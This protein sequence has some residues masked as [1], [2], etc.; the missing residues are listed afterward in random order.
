MIGA[1]AASFRAYSV[2]MRKTIWGILLLWLTAA[3]TTTAQPAADHARQ[4]AELNVSAL[5]P[6]QHAVLAVGIDISEGFHAQSR[7]PSNEYLIAFD[8]TMQPSDAIESYQPIYP[9]GEDHT[10]EV[11]GTL[12]VYTGK[13]IVYVPMV[14][15]SSAPIGALTL[16]GTMTY[17]ICDERACFQPENPSFEVTTRVVPVSEI[18]TPVNAALFEK[19]D[20]KV[21]ANLLP[22]TEVAGP[23][24]GIEVAVFGWKF[25]IGQSSYLLAFSLA[26]VVG[27][28]FNVMPCVLPVLPLKA[29]GFYE[30]SQHHRAMSIAFGMLFSAGIVFAFAVLAAL[31]LIFNQAWGELFSRGWFVWTLTAILAL[32]A[33]SQFGFFTFRLPVGVYN[34]SPRHDTLSG[35]FLFGIFAAVLSTPCTGPMFPPL[36]AWSAAQPKSLGVGVIMMV[37]VGM[38]L[39]YVIL[40]AFPQ[41]ARKI[42]RTGPWS[43]IVKQMMGFL[44]LAVAAYFV[45]SRLIA[46]EKFWWPV[47]GVIALAGVFLVARTVQL[48]PR[49]RPVTVATILAILLVG[50]ALLAT[51]RLTDPGIWTKYS[52]ETFAQARG[53]G[54]IVLVKFTANWC[55]NCQYIEHAVFGDER[56][57]DEIDSRHIIAIKA[58][59][60]TSDASGWALLKQLN[61]SGGIP[62]TAIYSPGKNE[63]IQLASI[64]TIAGLIEALDQAK[65]N[66]PLVKALNAN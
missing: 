18:V 3:G 52:P 60:T 54:Q 49:A 6:G 63:P 27:L 61:P 12:N 32:M 42:P 39:P 47:F 59:L 56:T 62:L 5:Q 29:I 48:V 15:K 37:G 16:R 30:A 44:L 66:S 13:V 1:D 24:G 22:A 25:S 14:V 19:F 53:S 45:A 50:G 26:I 9:P 20:P 23:G 38:A 2:F 35:N 8:V 28:I 36:L 21:F 51:L 10:Y 40:S 11:L 46:S 41:L 33:L 65:Q 34:F 55:G 4:F 57:R 58:D 31:V 43:E 17:Q 7:T 64:Y